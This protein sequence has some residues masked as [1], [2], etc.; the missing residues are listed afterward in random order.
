MNRPSFNVIMEPWIPVIGLDGRS[1]ELGIQPC[2]EQAHELR[3]IRDPSPISEFG[4]YRL[5]V[6]FVLDA[7]I[8][9]DRRPEDPL[10]LKVILQEGRFDS[11]M[12]KT[13]IEQGGDVF[14]LFHPKRPF[15][16]TEM[17]GSKTKP[18]AGMNPVA[19]SGT[20]VGHWRHAHEDSLAVSAQE[21][22]RLLT[23]IAPFM[24]AG[25]AG[26][27]PSING[28]PAIYALPL[29]RNLFE[30]LVFNIPLRRQDSGNGVVAWRSNRPPG[31]ERTEATTVEALT[32]RPRRIQLVPKI[33]ENNDAYVRE[34]MF[35]KGDST[36]L[37]WID[38]SLAY[39]YD[40]DKVT[41]VRM[42]EGRPL[43]RDAGP[44]LL[45]NETEHGKDEKKVSFRRPDVVEQAFALTEAGEPVAIQVYGM[46]TDLKMKVF[47]WGRS[48]W[49]IPA[50]LGRST[51]LGSLVQREIE[52]AEQAAFGLRNCIKA[53]YPRQGAGNKEALGC[54][55]GRSERV[56]WQHLE[57]RFHP[58]MKAFAALEPSAPDDPHLIASAARNWREAIGAFAIQQFESAAQ[59][60]DADSDALERQVRARSRLNATLKKVLP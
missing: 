40:K 8:L 37:S 22:A 10:E 20:N 44:L 1:A 59:D 57:L 7:L 2:L 53:L 19:P 30:T 50:N 3:E 14:D 51:R 36:R 48:A 34:M 60:M 5:L 41:P 32:W 46:R 43:W 26:L 28:A 56:Y 33:G 38:A 58:L 35:E 54:I 49:S 24:T 6:A 11:Q 12:F 47:E 39:R 31:Q 29:G 4:L 21:A 25:G 23:T 45:L 18:L 9:F 17:K 16:Q 27:S 42:R 52:R 15:L 13:Y 55:V